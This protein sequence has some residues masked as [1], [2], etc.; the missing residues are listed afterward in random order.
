MELSSFFGRPQ[1]FVR[2]LSIFIQNA[3]EKASQKHSETISQALLNV[4]D[5]TELPRAAGLLQFS[6][7]ARLYYLFML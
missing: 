6:K 4:R 2:S 3:H 1:C 7:N 5:L